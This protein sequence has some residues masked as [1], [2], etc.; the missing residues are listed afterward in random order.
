[1]SNTAEEL[2]DTLN[3]IE[4]D[5]YDG[6]DLGDMFT[7]AY[8]LADELGE[9]IDKLREES[10][11]LREQGARLFDKT[12]ELGTENDRLREQASRAW[13]L[14]LKHGA[15]HPCDLPEVDAVRDGLRELGVEVEQ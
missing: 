13:R 1:M 8:V 5:V 12:L 7:K 15:V 3:D 9:S 6:I 2:K 11:K 4:R 10:A 14:F